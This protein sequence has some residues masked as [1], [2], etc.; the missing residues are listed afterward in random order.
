[1]KRILL[2]FACCVCVACHNDPPIV[3][4]PQK[5]GY[6]LKEHL[7]NANKTIAQ[8][9]E[10]SINEYVERRGWTMQRLNEGARVWV[11]Q[12]GSGKQIEPEDSVHLRYDI[13]AINGKK[14]YQGVED[15]Y[16]AG[17]KQQLIGLDQAVMHL[18]R[19]SRAKIILPSNLGYG[20]G[21]DGDRITQSAILVFDVEVL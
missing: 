17:R 16:V 11:Y 6:D 12:Q 7:I 18:N 4:G 13:E 8:A 3:G 1:M 19:G 20:I 9:E 10:T 15:N 5:Q 2:I 14:I 21:G